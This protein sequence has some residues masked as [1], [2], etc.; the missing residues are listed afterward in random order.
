MKHASLAND[1][2]G[3]SFAGLGSAFMLPRLP[4]RN[5]S[6]KHRSAPKEKCP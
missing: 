3:T 4:S 2:A 6:M 5:G 1:A